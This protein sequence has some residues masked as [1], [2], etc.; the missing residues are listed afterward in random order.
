MRTSVTKFK[1]SVSGRYA[2]PISTEYG[3]IKNGTLGGYLNTLTDKGVTLP[4]SFVDAFVEFFEKGENQG[5]LDKLLYVM[6]FCGTTKNPMSLAT[7]LIAKVG[8]KEDATIMLSGD[9]SYTGELSDYANMAVVD[10]NN[11]IGVKQIANKTLL[12]QLSV[13][14]LMRSIPY[15]LWTYNFYGDFSKTEVQSADIR[16][17]GAR[18]CDIGSSRKENRLGFKTNLSGIDGYIVGRGIVK[19][20]ADF[21]SFKYY[22]SYITQTST[23]YTDFSVVGDINS[24]TSA[25]RAT[26]LLDGLTKESDFVSPEEVMNSRYGITRAV[27]KGGTTF[28]GGSADFTLNWLAVTD[29]TFTATTEALYRKA[30]GELLTALGKR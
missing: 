11:I 5:W 25:N 12:A 21:N 26:D 4:M 14:D 7:P 27:D 30:L 29:G 2:F 9:T 24:V 15:P 16:I 13:M 20:I 18:S 8:A 17:M 3:V 10:G 6:P 23:H 1:S 22:M 19:A 28:V